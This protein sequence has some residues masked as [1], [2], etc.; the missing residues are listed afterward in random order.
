MTSQKFPTYDYSMML[1]RVPSTCLASQIFEWA[2]NLMMQ[3]SSYR[4]H[5]SFIKNAIYWRW[6]LLS[7]IGN[8]PCWSGLRAPQ[9]TSIH[10]PHPNHIHQNFSSSMKDNCCSCYNEAI[11]NMQSPVSSNTLSPSY[12]GPASASHFSCSLW[13]TKCWPN[14][15]RECHFK[16]YTGEDRDPRFCSW[17]GWQ[18]NWI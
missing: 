6:D 8:W 1:Q 13:I 2:L 10:M 12:E 17:K 16:C 7:Q 14:L 5:Q 9:I 3:S 11:S 15:C 18:K 4:K